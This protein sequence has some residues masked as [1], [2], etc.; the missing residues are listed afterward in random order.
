MHTEWIQEKLA[1]ALANKFET[2]EELVAID[3]AVV[4]H[5][6]GTKLATPPGVIQ[7]IQDYLREICKLNRAS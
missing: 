6:L 2:V 1:I 7:S 3:P 4:S 5:D